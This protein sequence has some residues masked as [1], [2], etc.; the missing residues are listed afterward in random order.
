MTREKKENN[1]AVEAEGRAFKAKMKELQYKYTA[2]EKEAADLITEEETF[3]WFMKNFL[4]KEMDLPVIYY[5]D[6]LKEGQN[7][8]FLPY[9]VKMRDVTAKQLIEDADK[10]IGQWWKPIGKSE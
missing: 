3:K 10:F 4:L 8:V 6:P 9:E 7:P 2:E 1:D 5:F